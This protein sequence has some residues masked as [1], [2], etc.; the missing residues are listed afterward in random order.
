MA[1]NQSNLTSGQMRVIT[2][3][4]IKSSSLIGSRRLMVSNNPETLNIIN[5][6]V[7]RGTLWHDYVNTSSTT[8]LHRVFGWHLN[9]TGETIKIGLTVQNLSSTNTIELQSVKRE[10]CSTNNSSQYIT[11]VGQ[12]LA[13]GCLGRTLDTINPI[14]NRFGQ[15]VGLIE[16]YYIPNGYLVGFLFEFS[17]VRYSGTGNLNYYIRTV[18]SKNTSEDLRII[19]SSPLSKSGPHPRGSWSQADIAGT[20]PIYTVGQTS[21]TSI[22]NGLTDSLLNASTSY[23]NSNAVNNPGHF[24]TTYRVRIP[25]NNILGVAKNIRIRVNPRGGVYAGAAKISAGTYGIP[26]LNTT[27]PN[28]AQVMDYTANPGTTYAKFTVMHAGASNLPLAI[29]V[30]TI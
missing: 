6:S 19:T 13:K 2:P 17:V 3:T 28:A 18:T 29:Y 22:S 10:K 25:V 7:T 20:T 1:C 16:T 5:F 26:V 23:D 14:H 8:T 11:H 15:S 4:N 27:K 12:H 30:T 9:N 21:S 24:G